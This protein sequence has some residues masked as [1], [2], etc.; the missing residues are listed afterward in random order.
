MSQ[1]I[2]KIVL[3]E[4]EIQ[5]KNYGL[6]QVL[7]VHSVK[8]ALGQATSKDDP[9]SREAILLWMDDK[10]DSYLLLDLTQDRWEVFSA[11]LKQCF[12]YEELG[13]ALQILYQGK[14]K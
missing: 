5:I 1:I 13:A 3:H 6:D 11:E 10:R 4:V 2:E 7:S 12:I 14:R 8:S 9:L